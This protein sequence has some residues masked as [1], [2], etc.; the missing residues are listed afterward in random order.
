MATTEKLRKLQ[1][2]ELKIALEI[3]RVCEKNGLRFFLTGGTLLGA[4]R[5]GGFIPWD[6]DMD[7]SFPRA[8]YDA[9]TAVC[10]TDLGPEFLLQTWDTDPSYPFPAGKIRLKG[11]HAQE[12]FAAAGNE[13]GIYVDIFPFDNVP[14]GTWAR[15]CQGWRYFLGKRLLWMKKGYGRCIVDESIAKAW[16]YRLAALL[17]APLSY[18]LL[19]RWMDRSMRRY[20]GEPTRCAVVPGV[21]SFASETIDRSWLDDLAPVSFEG[22]AFPAFRR[23]E[24]YLRKVYGDYM[25]LPPE[26]RRAGHEFSILDF[27][28]YGPTGGPA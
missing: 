1:L 27:G 14:D 17:T 13:N 6:D 25:R 23:K 9:F 10:K 7:I 28:P 3:K 26:D 20:N 19:K 2:L 22:H 8:D 4:V 5:H 18:D 24:D 16:K 15:R 21:Y 11:T 12:R